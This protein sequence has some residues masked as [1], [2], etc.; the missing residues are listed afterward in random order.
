MEKRQTPTQIRKAEFDRTA[1]HA[2]VL[3]EDALAKI[4]EA[5]KWGDISLEEH[6]EIEHRICLEFTEFPEPDDD[7]PLPDRRPGRV[8]SV[9]CSPLRTAWFGDAVSP[10]DAA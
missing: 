2:R 1:D 5:L 3:A 7:D 6:E 8:G 10:D 9:V 4:D